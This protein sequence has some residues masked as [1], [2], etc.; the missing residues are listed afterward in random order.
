[1]ILSGHAFATKEFGGKC[2]LKKGL[3]IPSKIG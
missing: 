1:M 3:R 2:R